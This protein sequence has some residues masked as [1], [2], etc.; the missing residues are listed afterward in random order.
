MCGI[1]GIVS[2]SMLD[3]NDFLRVRK[4]NQAL[5]HRGP[6]SEGFHKEPKAAFAMRRL[7]IIDLESG[8]QPLFNE[9]KSV[10]LVANGEIYNHEELRAEL[11]NKGHHFKTK[12][13]CE[14][15]LH[16]YE[17][18]G[19]ECVHKLRGMFAFA[20]LDKEKGQV[21]LA[22]DR[23]S[24]KPLYYY[25]D[26]HQ[27][28]FS[29]ELK[30]LLTNFHSKDLKINADAINQYFHFQFVPEPHTCIENIQ[31][32][33]AGHHI[34]ISLKSF[35]FSLKKYW[36]FDDI[37][38]VSGNPSE[39]I[40]EAFDDLSRL[41]IRADV[42]V[43]ISLSGGID[44]SAIACHAAKYYKEHMHAFSVG[45]PNRPQNDERSMAKKLAQKLGMHFYEIELS[46]D[47]FVTSFP[48]VVSSM[49]NPIAD[50][51]AFAQKSLHAFVNKTGVRVILGGLGGDELFWGYN[52]GRTAVDVNIS[53]N[54]EQPLFDKSRQFNKSTNSYPD[55][56]NE[57]DILYHPLFFR[58]LREDNPNPI[59]YLDKAISHN[60]AHELLSI[61]KHLASLY[62]TSFNQNLK[63]K[64]PYSLK[65][66]PKLNI[67]INVCK[68]IFETWLYSNC[69]T[70]GDKL[71][72]AS[73]IETRLPF[74]DFKFVEL[75]VG[76]RKTSTEDYK[77]GHKQWLID[78]MQGIVP[79]E[80]L[81]RKKMGFEPP[82]TEWFGA[83]VSEYK[84][85]CY[86][87]YLVQEGIMQKDNLI[88]FL[89][90]A[91]IDSKLLSFAYK[92]VLMEVWLRLFINEEKNADLV[93]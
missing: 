10:I 16:L 50:I 44:S 65:Q 76:L 60:K 27:F 4:M 31:K 15:I 11:I 8:D 43:G 24:E 91:M 92:I 80:I 21:F 73:S 3:E 66:S 87:G 51:S 74:L 40:R 55:F 30:S 38:P 84:R 54:H 69:I 1:C 35:S 2:K 37:K 22:R 89:N 88:K 18:L 56:L 47:D 41:I 26:D 9:D 85:L 77:L 70:L 53:E 13:D 42:P 12:S 45:Y 63:I 75:V 59:K 67:P 48:Y 25:M 62:T 36:D 61:C 34:T 64:A 32:L 93:S 19:E 82:L 78:A 68:N 33:P 17:D 46:T 57:D 7:K 83:I 90:Q 58:N 79:D 23:L 72:M 71:S 5:Y 28:L 6:D 86:D 52:W 39:L 29:S 81:N 49:D 14:T 20:I